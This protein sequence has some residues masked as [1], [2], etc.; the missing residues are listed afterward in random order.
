[1]P[2]GSDNKEDRPARLDTLRSRFSQQP[3]QEMQQTAAPAKSPT[4]PAAGEKKSNR[5]RHTLYLDRDIALQVDTAYKVA[6][7]S[8]FPLEVDK[9][10][11]LEACF[12]YALEHQEEVKSRMVKNRIGG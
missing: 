10:D 12:Q 3:D 2:T 8:L 5:H 4:A 6:A 7:H 9:S 11:F 1:M